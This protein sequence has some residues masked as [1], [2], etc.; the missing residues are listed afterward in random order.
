MKHRNNFPLTVSRWAQL[1]TRRVKIT[2]LFVIIPTFFAP[3]RSE[4]NKSINWSSVKWAQNHWETF[5]KKPVKKPMKSSETTA[6]CSRLNH[7]HPSITKVKSR[8]MSNGM[9]T[10]F[11]SNIALTQ[12]NYLQLNKWHHCVP[13]VLKRWNW[14]VGKRA[15]IPLDSFPGRRRKS[16]TYLAES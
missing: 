4:V 14:V 10:L 11:F 3:P 2:D 5:S 9:R 13:P 1:E 6:I 15:T 7:G 12:V 8:R 16:G